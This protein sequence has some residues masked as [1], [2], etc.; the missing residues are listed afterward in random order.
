MR[1]SGIIQDH[2][3]NK[4]LPSTYDRGNQCLDIIAVSENI[5]PRDILRCG[6][7]PFYSLGASNH[8]PLYVDFDIATLFYGTLPD[9][10]NHTFRR[11]TTKNTHK[12]KKYIE[13]LSRFVQEA[14]LVGKVKSIKSEITEFLTELKECGRDIGME[15]EEILTQKGIN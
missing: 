10:T 11:F 4:T 15:N 8:C 13:H 2:H 14:K 1:L 12:C 3:Q 7:L 9:L 6:I 5:E